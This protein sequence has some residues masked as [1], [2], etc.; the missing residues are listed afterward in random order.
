MDKITK[1]S[2][3]TIDDIAKYIRIDSAILEI[4]KRNLNTMLAVA[5]NFVK[6]YTGLNDKEIDS[7][8]DLV[9]V[10][11]VLCQ[12]MYDSRTLYIDKTNLNK[13]V[14][15]ILGTHDNNLL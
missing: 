13:V 10:I 15:F 9:I 1:V 12:D 7:Y 5:I 11:F 3:I 14:E 8:N 4:E 2:E 6:N